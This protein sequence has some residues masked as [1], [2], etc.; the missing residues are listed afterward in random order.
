ML[1]GKDCA[2]ID[3]TV[4]PSA[5]QIL[6]DLVI[7]L[8]DLTVNSGAQTA[9]PQVLGGGL[10]G[11]ETVPQPIKALGQGECFGLV[12]VRHGEENGA[13]VGHPHA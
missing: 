2:G 12:L 11:T 3:Y 13:V 7:A 1:P 9:L 4:D 6:K 10:G 8:A 5:A